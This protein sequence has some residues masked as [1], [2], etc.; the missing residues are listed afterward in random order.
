MQKTIGVVANK[1]S[2]ATIWNI[3]NLLSIFRIMTIPV[4]VAFLFS[5]SPAA[6]FL[7]AL[8]FGIASTTDA[9]DGYIARYQNSE[10]AIGKLLDPLADKLLINSALIMLIPLG[11]IPAWMVVLIVGREVAVTGLRGIASI[12]GRVISASTWGKAKTIFQSFAL[13]GLMLHYEYFGIN[14]H[15]VGMI[16]MWIALAITLGSGFDYFFKFYQ[17]HTKEEE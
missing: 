6:S 17:A 16:L 5:P 2:Q 15:L 12:E 13:G 14:F 9:L 4:V 1:Q 3:P 8:L 11:R 7:A 10:T